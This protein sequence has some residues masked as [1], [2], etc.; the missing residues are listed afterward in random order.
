M[1][2]RRAMERIEFNKLALLHVDGVRGIH[3][4]RVLN[5]HNDG[6]MIHS[7]TYHIVAFNFDLSLDGFKTTRHCRVVWRNGNICGVQFVDQS[8]TVTAP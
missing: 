1:H 2:E 3:P 4:C 7:S 8:S 6:A 5:L